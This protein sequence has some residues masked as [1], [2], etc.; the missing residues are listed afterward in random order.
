MAFWRRVE[1]YMGY[2]MEEFNSRRF[3]LEQAGI[4]C[5]YKI[6]ERTGGGGFSGRRQGGF[7]LNPDYSRQFYLYVDKDDV[8][9][10]RA[11]LQRGER[12]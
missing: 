4:R 1:V 5:E 2:S 11:V 7:G 6:M 3:R 8:E 9:E 10:A 12:L